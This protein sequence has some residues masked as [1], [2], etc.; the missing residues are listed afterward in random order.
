M[1]LTFSSFLATSWKRPFGVQHR[2]ILFPFNGDL[3]TSLTWRSLAFALTLRRAEVSLFP[4]HDIIGRVFVLIR[5]CNGRG[6]DFKQGYIYVAGP[7][8]FTPRFH[9]RHFQFLGK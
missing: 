9:L 8:Q 4:R 3:R 2:G 6:N 1:T 7:D 5:H